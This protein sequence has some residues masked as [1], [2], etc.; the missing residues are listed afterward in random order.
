MM[1]TRYNRFASYSISSTKNQTQITENI[2]LPNI[3][4]EKIYYTEKSSKRGMDIY[5]Q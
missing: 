4:P 1:D 5:F 2:A 3:I